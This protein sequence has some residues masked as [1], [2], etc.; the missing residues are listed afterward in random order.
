[1]ARPLSVSLGVQGL[2]SYRYNIEKNLKKDILH[3]LF[4]KYV[5][6]L[7]E[8]C[9]FRSAK[10]VLISNYYLS[11]LNSF[12]EPENL[13]EFHKNHLQRSMHFT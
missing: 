7:I 1:M 10:S 4:I 3:L 13:S 2:N 12:I 9:N 5:Q 11:K 6:K 8:I